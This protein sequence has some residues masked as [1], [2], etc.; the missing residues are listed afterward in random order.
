MTVIAAAT[1]IEPSPGWLVQLVRAGAEAGI[2][3]GLADWFAITVVLVTLS[4]FPFPTQPFCRERKRSL[5]R[6]LSRTRR[7]VLSS[8]SFVLNPLFIVLFF[9]YLFWMGLVAGLVFV[10]LAFI[11]HATVFAVGRLPFVLRIPAS[12]SISRAPSRSAES[13]KR[14]GGGC[15]EP[16]LLDRGAYS[17]YRNVVWAV[18]RAPEPTAF[19]VLSLVVGIAMSTIGQRMLR[20]DEGRALLRYRLLPIAGWKLLVTQDMTFLISLAYHGFT[21]SYEQALHLAWSLSQFGRYPSLRRRAIQRRWRF[22]GG[23]P[24]F[25][26]AQ[27]LLG[28]FA[29]IGAARTGT[30]GLSSCLR[31]LRGFHILGRTALGNAP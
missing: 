28:G 11:V 4:G 1:H 7:I 15:R 18:G 13:R 12:L 20:L 19:P 8:I 6:P 25:G 17:C 9:G 14:C 5:P 30:L 24:R 10:L 2:I 26:V 27:V 3:G 31:P 29:G 21:R 23:D 16:R 22:V